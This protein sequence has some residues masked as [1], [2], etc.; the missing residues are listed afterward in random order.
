MLKLYGKQQI[1]LHVHRLFEVVACAT[2]EGLWLHDAVFEGSWI[3]QEGGDV[4]AVESS[5]EENCLWFR[6]D[7]GCQFLIVSVSQVN[8]LVKPVEQIWQKVQQ[9]RIYLH[10]SFQNDVIQDL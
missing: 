3:D 5:H 10:L 8:Q 7:C 2:C 9:N 1:S 6:S 4:D